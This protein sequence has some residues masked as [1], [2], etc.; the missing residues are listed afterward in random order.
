MNDH[1]PDHDPDDGDDHGAPTYIG[2][3]PGSPGAPPRAQADQPLTNVEPVPLLPN[4]DKRKGRHCTHIEVEKVN[5]PNVGFRGNVPASTDLQTLGYE[6]GDGIYNLYFKNKSKAT[7][8]TSEGIIIDMGLKGRRSEEAAEGG[9][10]GGEFVTGGDN[11]E[12]V[13][14]AAERNINRI[15]EVT[16]KAA[17]D[18]AQ[19]AQSFTQLVSKHMES[20][21]ERDRAFF[22]G[23]AEMQREFYAAQRDQQQEAHR[24][25]M[26]MSQQRFEQTLL[27]QQQM[28]KGSDAQPQLGPVEIIGL[29]EKAMALGQ[30]M[31]GGD[32]D[33]ATVALKEGS[34]GLA[35]ILDAFKT[36]S[37]VDMAK[38]QLAAQTQAR[39]L[40]PAPKQPAEPRRAMRN[41]RA[42]AEENDN[43]SA[44]DALT[45]EC[46]ARNIDVAALL[47][48][49]TQNI[50]EQPPAPDDAPDDA[51]SAPDAPDLDT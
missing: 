51:D 42:I 34:Q 45:Q 47:R 16:T 39:Q 3:R 20:A 27:L 35:S 9:E 49:A 28:F 32:G 24:A 22:T 30:G 18:E 26:A 43:R 25:D 48:D 36:K 14:A 17:H 13:L 41:P 11:S 8:E 7:I 44:L 12:A 4:W 2:R 10:E 29:F 46:S 37:Q 21:S 19:R 40:P 1:D 50:R 31:A 5:P 23:Q 15:M 6:F 38:L 33:L